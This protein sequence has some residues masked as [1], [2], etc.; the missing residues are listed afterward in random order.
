LF[1]R[2]KL[3]SDLPR[4]TGRRMTKL[5]L[6]AVAVVGC[7]SHTSRGE[8][9]AVGTYIGGG[10]MLFGADDCEYSGAPGV[11]AANGATPERGPRFVRG[12]GAITIACPKVTRQVTA[13]EPTGAKIWGE[14]EMKSGEK[15]LLTANLV[16]DKD[17]LVGEARIEW[18]L[19]SDCTNVASFGPVLG[20]QD[21]GG[22]DRSRDLVATG[23]GSCHVTVTLTTGSALDNIPG[24][25]FE[26]SLLVTVL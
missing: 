10:S 1:T 3:V 5:A 17:D 23:K 13:L 4:V 22:K 18:T 19:G 8:V 15:Q 16:A 14:P 9:H 26:Q 25:T 7:G 12:A 6:L 11:F 2:V 20:A 21:T 24:K